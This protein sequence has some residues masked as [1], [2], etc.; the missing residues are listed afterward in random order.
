MISCSYENV[1]N[2]QDVSSKTLDAIKVKIP[3]Q[4]FWCVYDARR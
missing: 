4:T 3:D 2:I 1:M